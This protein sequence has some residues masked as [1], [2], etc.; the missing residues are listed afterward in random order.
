MLSKWLLVRRV[1]GSFRLQAHPA[2]FRP[3]PVRVSGDF[4]FFLSP[5]IH[6]RFKL[7]CVGNKIYLPNETLNLHVSQ[8]V[9][10]V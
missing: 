7:W 2:G 9:S 5:D 1:L 3:G 6:E 10:F 8:S 4:F